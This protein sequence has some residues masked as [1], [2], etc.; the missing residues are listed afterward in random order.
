MPNLGRI[1]ENVSEAT[2]NPFEASP[3]KNQVWLTLRDTTRQNVRFSDLS[4]LI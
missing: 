3:L 2:E 1:N 4:E